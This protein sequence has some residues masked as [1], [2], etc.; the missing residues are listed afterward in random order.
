MARVFKICKIFR[1]S[2][3]RITTKRWLA[4]WLAFSK[5]VKSLEIRWLALQVS[6]GSRNGS[7]FY[8]VARVTNKLWLALARGIA[9]VIKICKIFRNSVARVTS[10]RWL[11]LARGMARVI[12]IYK[13]FRNSVARVT[14][15]RWLAEWL[16]L[17]KYVKSLVMRWFA[18][19]VSVGSRNGSRYPHT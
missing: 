1:N 14:S 18:L 13:I 7:R 16:A 3:A 12:K 2:V 8:L 6:V 15:K 9:R 5:Y 17:S 19:E 4:E 10:K 11:A